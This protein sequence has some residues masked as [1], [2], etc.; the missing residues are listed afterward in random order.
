MYIR[1]FL[2]I[3]PLFVIVPVILVWVTAGNEARAEFGRRLARGVHRNPWVIGAAVLNLMS[4]IILL[5]WL[6]EANH[7]NLRMWALFQPAPSLF[8]LITFWIAYRR[9]RT[10]PN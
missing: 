2:S 7:P 8:L 6:V 1:A 10:R 4:A 5:V 3:L 9:G